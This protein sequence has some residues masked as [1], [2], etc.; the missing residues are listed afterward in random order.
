MRDETSILPEILKMM[1]I[2]GLSLLTKPFN[3]TWRSGTTP[4]E[5][6][7]GVVVPILK[8]GTRMFVLVIEG[9][10]FSASQERVSLGMLKR[11][12]PIDS[13]TYNPEMWPLSVLRNNRL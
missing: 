3:V 8:K 4:L 1:D 2:V 9:P 10:L 12:V 6:Q 11:E 5:E 13:Q 7:T